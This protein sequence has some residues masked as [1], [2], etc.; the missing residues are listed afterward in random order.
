MRNYHPVRY[1]A[2]TKNLGV[3]PILRLVKATFHLLS[4]KSLVR[5]Y[6][7]LP[8]RN[9]EERQGSSN[10]R[11]LFTICGDF[12]LLHAVDW[13]KE[14][15]FHFYCLEELFSLVHIHPVP[16]ISQLQVRGAK[17]C[18]QLVMLTW[19]SQGRSSLIWPRKKAIFKPS[20]KS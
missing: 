6:L 13:R 15:I 12:Q 18:Y 11:T 17:W 7:G 14:Q 16:S 4:L 20:S 5:D 9:N 8:V 10:V 1:S 3:C 2:W 19:E